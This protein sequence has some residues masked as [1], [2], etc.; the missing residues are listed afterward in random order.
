MNLLDECL[1]DPQYKEY[2][3]ILKNGLPRVN[4]QHQKHVVIVGAGMA[5]LSA[6]KTLQDAGHRVTILEASH[7][8]GGRIQTYRESDLWY[9][10]V[11]PMR[12]P[13]SHRL[14]REYVDHFGLKM[15][16]FIMDTEE[17]VYLFKGIRH[18]QTEVTKTPNMFGFA[19]SPEEEGKSPDEMS[20]SMLKKFVQENNGKNCREILDQLDGASIQSFLMDEGRLSYGAYQ[21]FGDYMNTNGQ[22]YLSYMEAALD[23]NVFKSARLDEITGGFDQLPLALA[24]CLGNVIKLNST[25]VKIIR[26]AKSVIVQYRKGKSAPITNIIADYVLVTSTAKA[27]RR[28]DF[29]PLLSDEKTYALRYINY[30]SAT[31]IFLVC[32][33]RFWE[34][35]G[36]LGGRSY[37]DRPSRFMYY[38]SHNFTGGKDV[39]LASYTIGEDS[40]FFLSLSDEQC[41][42]VVLEDLAAIHQRQKEELRNLCPKAVVKKWSLDSNS[43]G[44]FAHFIPYQ[45]IYMYEHLS[46]PEGRIHFAGEHTSAPHGW[47]DTA[48]KSGIRAAK[49][50]YEDAKTFL[51]K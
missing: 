34:R 20:S 13:E 3:N 2:E 11:G 29:S 40:L 50:I 18:V 30:I 47:I 46:Q 51:H 27:T 25:V 26:K 35:D 42:D 6:A 7:H 22:A 14:V 5:G 12:L 24:R 8:V 49:D 10:D 37:T 19:L 38:P 4:K 9:V 44:A 33:E 1:Q 32:N 28:I 43:M 31:K 21:M 39:L 48:I 23:M 41:V 45:Y 16:K 17:N 36:L 15:N